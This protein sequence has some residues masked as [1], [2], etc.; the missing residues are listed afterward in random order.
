MIREPEWIKNIGEANQFCTA[1]KSSLRPTVNWLQK[2]LASLTPLQ[3][4]EMCMCLHL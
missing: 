4:E 2:M 3:E 1:T